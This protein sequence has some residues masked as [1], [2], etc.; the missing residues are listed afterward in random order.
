M[1]S[2]IITRMEIV[3]ASV[4]AHLELQ[5]ICQNYGFGMLAVVH[6]TRLFKLRAGKDFNHL[7][8]RKS[9]VKRELQHGQGSDA[10]DSYAR[11]YF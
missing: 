3:M 7:A 8:C 2:H 9:R 1:I 10:I 5:H 4:M 6:G 11:G